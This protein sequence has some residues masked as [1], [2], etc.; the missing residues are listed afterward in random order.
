MSTKGLMEHKKV[1]AVTLHGPEAGKLAG[2]AATLTLKP[3]WQYKGSSGPFDL[4]SV[5]HGHFI[6]KQSREAGKPQYEGPDFS[7]GAPAAPRGQSHT[8]SGE[9]SGPASEA[10]P[11][12][13]PNAT[14]WSGGRMAVWRT[15]L[16]NPESGHEVGG[17]VRHNKV[18]P[19]GELERRAREAAASQFKGDS[20]AYT[21]VSIKKWTVADE[22]KAHREGTM[23][24]PWAREHVL[25]GDVLG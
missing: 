2:K 22:K 5:D 13:N 20:A 11:P 4:T 21:E 23:G 24:S 17:W 16:A 9:S 12:A 14:P 6:V 8:E 15:I 3:L 19:R 10:I 25:A 7:K 1:E 18:L